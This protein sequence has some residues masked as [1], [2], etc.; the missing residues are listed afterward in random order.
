MENSE[1]G[2]EEMG[3]E[4]EDAACR[5]VGVESERENVKEE[6]YRQLYQLAHLT[7]SLF[8]DVY[9]QRPVSASHNAPFRRFSRLVFNHPLLD[10]FSQRNSTYVKGTT[11]QDIDTI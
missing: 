10:R 1:G 2:A 7:K 9:Q 4:A 8:D 6:L 3:V 11:L 5:R